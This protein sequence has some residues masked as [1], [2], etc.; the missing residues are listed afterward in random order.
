MILISR[1]NPSK[2]PM[3]GQLIMHWS[4]D[5]KV[6]SETRFKIF[7][8]LH[9]D[10]S[11]KLI[12]ADDPISVCYSWI[13]KFFNSK[14]SHLRF[15]MLEINEHQLPLN[16]LKRK[17]RAYIF[18]ILSLVSLRLADSVVFPSM[19]R[20]QYAI[21][22][23]G[24]K[25]SNKC[26]VVWNIP[27]TNFGKSKETSL[28]SEKLQEIKKSYDVIAIYAG[29][30]QPG[31]GLDDILEKFSTQQLGALIVCGEDKCNLFN[32][33][34]DKLNN[35]FYFGS[36][37]SPELFQLYYLC[38]IGILSY[39]NEPLN[40]KYCAP[41]KIWEYLSCGLKILGNNNYALQNEWFDYVDGY[42]NV[43]EEEFVDLLMRLKSMPAKNRSNLSFEIEKITSI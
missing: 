32:S 12:V 11:I 5:L 23:Y 3:L 36:L 9:V 18:R 42:Y 15:W 34:T 17:I 14:D 35:I 2:H 39:E 16:S 38:D 24:L 4:K 41:V 7:N 40:V 22:S 8:V 25:N 31:R 43:G 1:N 29:S 28:F 26:S 10:D 27:A 30:L 21:N 19:L 20:L 6:L 13:Y 33:H 37:P